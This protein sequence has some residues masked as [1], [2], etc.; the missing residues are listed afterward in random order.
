MMIRRNFFVGFKRTSQQILCLSGPIAF[1]LLVQALYNIV[2]SFYVSRYSADG[3]TALSLAFPVQLFL[4]ALATGVSTG[5]GILVSYYLG[6]RKNELALEAGVN[7]FLLSLFHW[8]LCAGLCWPM[9]SVYF[10][11]FSNNVRVQDMGM[12]YTFGICMCSGF[13]FLENTS[14]RILYS[15]GNSFGPMIAQVAGAVFNIILDPVLIYGAFGIREMGIAG[16]AA[17][18]VMGQFFSLVLSLLFLR[19]GSMRF[20]K[21]NFM[22]S[23]NL[24]RG[25][26]KAG[27]PTFFMQ[28]LVAF[29]VSGLNMVLKPFGEYAIMSLGIYYKLQT[30]LLMP[31]NSI[32]LAVT[33]LMSYGCGEKNYAQVW[34]IYRCALS[35]SFFAMLLGTGIFWA[36]PRQLIAIFSSDKGLFTAAVPALRIISLSFPFFSFTIIIPVL[37]QV[38]GYTRE[39]LF[40]TFARQIVFLVPIAW[41]LSNFGL[42]YIWF[43]FPVSEILAAGISWIYRNRIYRE[44]AQR[45]EL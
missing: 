28:A 16:A 8:V 30:F 22:V 18:T 2:D 31:V 19:K 5:C 27:F 39:N 15:Q 36:F 6:E 32:S 20:R 37:L 33:P 43:T 42:K 29:Y 44:F 10:Y 41:V 34:K 23:W 38:A 26:Y 45:V 21:K 17:A 11:V 25:I 9:L 24:C 3:L 13:Q 1:S 7:G 40:I 14:S 12:A 35:I 4:L